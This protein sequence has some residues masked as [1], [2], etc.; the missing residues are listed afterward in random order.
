VVAASVVD[1]VCA[2]T[3]ASSRKLQRSERSVRDCIVVVD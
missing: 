2:A 3:K 1:A